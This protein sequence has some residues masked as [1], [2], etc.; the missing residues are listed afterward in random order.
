MNAS[1]MYRPLSARPDGNM[2]NSKEK[3]PEGV[4]PCK[5]ASGLPTGN[6]GPPLSAAKSK[7]QDKT[8]TSNNASLRCAKALN[9]TVT[10]P[11]PTKQSRASLL[12]CHPLEHKQSATGA[13]PQPADNPSSDTKS[14]LSNPRLDTVAMR[15]DRAISKFGPA[16][17]AIGQGTVKAIVG[18]IAT[19]LSANRCRSMD[20]ADILVVDDNEFNRFLLIQLLGR[21]GFRCG[22]VPLH[23]LLCRPLTGE[24]QCQSSQLSQAVVVG[25]TN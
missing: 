7:T 23:C 18:R 15:S 19:R 21:C 10:R 24:W 4:S 9:T 8:H 3:S 25:A 2:D 16:Q 20:C 5:R 6:L 1:N 11:N 12:G 13:L 17:T 14:H 22:T